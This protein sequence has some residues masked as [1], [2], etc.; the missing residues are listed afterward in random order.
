MKGLAMKM[1]FLL[2]SMTSI[3]LFAYAANAEAECSEAVVNRKILD[4]TSRASRAA[5]GTDA[6]GMISCWGTQA[7]VYR[8][9]DWKKYYYVQYSCSIFGVVRSTNLYF[10]MK[11]CESVD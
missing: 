6:E 11:T 8:A 4:Q 1:V 9:W 10:D 5:R 2:F 7:R 3:V